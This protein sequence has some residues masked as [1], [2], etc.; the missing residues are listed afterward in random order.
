[1]RILLDTNVALWAISDDRRLSRRARRIIEDIDNTVCVSVANLWE[2][3]IKHA[4]RREAMPVSAAAVRE[5]F[6]RSGYSMIEITAAHAVRV[7]RLPLIHA[8][9][10]DRI[11][12][13]Q[14]IEEG[15]R[16]LTHDAVVPK[17]SDLVI[18]V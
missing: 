1:M 5:Y 16:L 8:D 4:L 15:C 7:E 6:S 13:A 2:I 18:Q 12:V 10:F 9:P 14:A 11:L 3:A 17:Y